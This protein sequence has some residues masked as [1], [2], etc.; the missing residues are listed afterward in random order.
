[1]GRSILRW[2]V[3][4]PDGLRSSVWRIWGNVKGDVYV[5]VRSLGGITKV[6]FH[7]DGKCQ[8]GFT[9]EYAPTAASRFQTQTRHWETWR[10]PTQPVAR[11]LRILIP[12][13]ELRRFAGHD[14]GTVVWLPSPAPGLV[15]TISVML[16]P[17]D[18][19]LELPDELPSARIIGTVHTRL[20]T[21]WAFSADSAPDPAW[22]RAIDTE[23]AKLAALPRPAIV[24]PG[25]R[26]TVWH[27]RADHDRNVLELAYDS[28]SAVG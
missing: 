14:T 26:A 19:T 8:V 11:V 21:A 5:A 25:L 22:A 23:R 17:P 2:A 10:L 16:A 7:R 13:A 3:G 27:S 12:G 6:S 9:S 18:L 4:T 24:S 28:S 1:M 20:R 15:S